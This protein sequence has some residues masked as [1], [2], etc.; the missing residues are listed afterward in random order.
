MEVVK[1]QPVNDRIATWMQQG[2]IGRIIERIIHD[3][4]VVSCKSYDI[5]EANGLYTYVFDL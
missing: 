2:E 3:L 1:I 4:L 5:I